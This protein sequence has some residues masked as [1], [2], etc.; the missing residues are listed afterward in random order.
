MGKRQR[1]RKSLMKQTE[2]VIIGAG[3]AGITAALYLKRAN[4]PFLWLE[5]GAPGGKLLNIAEVG[6][7]PG[8]PSRSGFELALELLK[9][10]EGLG[11]KPQRGDVKSVENGEAGFLVKTDQETIESKTVVVATGLSN[12]PTIK[13]EKEFFGKGVSYCATCDGPLYRN[14]TAIIYGTGDRALEEALYLA[15]LVGKLYLLSPDKEYQGSAHL[16]ENLS[17]KNNV[18]LFL[19]ATIKEIKGDMRVSE[20]VFEDLEGT[21]SLETNILFPL[22]GEKSASGFLSSLNVEMDRGFLVVDDSLMSN[23]PGL[24]GAGDIVKKKLR[25]VATAVGD[26]ATVSSGVITYLNALKKTKK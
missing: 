10:T 25:Q 11:V 18:E 14:K 16:L 19:N 9:S 12:V 17:E 2:V 6:N 22:Y 5:K 23:V 24:F 20:I 1:R 4:V 26:G 13:G 21:H 15:N 7:Y 3:P 8:L